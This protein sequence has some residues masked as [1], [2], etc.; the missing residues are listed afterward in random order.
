MPPKAAPSRSKEWDEW[1]AKCLGCYVCERVHPVLIFVSS[2]FSK[3]CR[4]WHCPVCIQ[5]ASL[6]TLVASLQPNQERENHLT[7]DIKS[8]AA[9]FRVELQQISRL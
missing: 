1:N 9:H 8:I 7:G 3:D 6:T 4:R 2:Q 5:I